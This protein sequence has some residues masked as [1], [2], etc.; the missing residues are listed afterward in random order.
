MRR[1]SE[2]SSTSD[3]EKVHRRL[4][5]APLALSL[6]RKEKQL[7]KIRAFQTASLETVNPLNSCSSLSCWRAVFGKRIYNL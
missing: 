7:D 4:C 1:H 6:T 2:G 3:G 5:L